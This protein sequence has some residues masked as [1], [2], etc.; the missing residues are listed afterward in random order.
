M[1]VRVGKELATKK[2]WSK[3]NNQNRV[4]VIERWLTE[5]EE[6]DEKHSPSYG[7]NGQL[8]QSRGTSSLW[9]KCTIYWMSPPY[10]AVMH[11]P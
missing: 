10:Y 9:P 7:Q 6:A 11:E 4:T 1:E 8:V 3:V 5:G 2:Q